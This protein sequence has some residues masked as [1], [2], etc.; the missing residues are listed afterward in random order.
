MDTYRNMRVFVEA[1]VA[2][3]PY[4]AAARERFERGELD[5]AWLTGVPAPDNAEER[6]GSGAEVAGTWWPARDILRLRDQLHYPGV[7][8]MFDLCAARAGQW[9]DKAEADVAAGATAR[10]LASELGALTKLVRREFNRDA[11]PIEWRK[12]ANLYS[13]RMTPE[14]AAIWRS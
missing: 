14:F 9:V 13:Y 5:E 1:T 6:D 12:V 3:A 4:M 11:W 8:A 2:S 10:Q 7:Q